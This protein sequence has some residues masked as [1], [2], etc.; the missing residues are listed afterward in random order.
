MAEENFMTLN[1]AGRHLIVGGDSLIGSALRLKLRQLNRD[2]TVT[3]RRYEQASSDRIFYDLMMANYSFDTEYD[4]VFLSAGITNM[5]ICEAEPEKAYQI[6]VDA[7]VALAHQFLANGSRVVFISSNTVFD[8]DT[9]HPDEDASYRY[10]TQYGRQKAE[11]ERRLLALGSGVV[12]IRITKIVS[13]DIVLFQ[14]LYE[15][16]MQNSQC[17]LFND[18][19]M[20]PISM[21]YLCDST[22]KIVDS[23]L[24]GIFH[25]SGAE[26]MSYAEFGYRL[27]NTIG[28]S[29]SLVNPVSAKSVLFKP[30]YASLGM[31]RTTQLLDISP[32]ASNSVLSQLISNR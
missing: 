4:C 14:T 8:G 10:T 20:C 31:R 24:D 7:T 23:Q 30:K 18:L 21:Q 32:E 15:R 5:S 22:I 17:D 6:N 2:V 28:V 1:E 16:L 26:D 13:L 25:L 3:T 27:A 19:M 12:I 11:A 29:D 9:K